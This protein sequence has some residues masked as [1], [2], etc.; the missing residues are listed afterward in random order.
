MR[1]TVTV[2]DEIG[3]EVKSR[4][5]NVSAYVSDAL[6]E[7]LRKEKRDAARRDL[8]RFAGTGGVDPDINEINQRWRREGDRDFQI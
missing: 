5:D 3:K 2:P 7:R 1:I 4:T 8:L 6:E